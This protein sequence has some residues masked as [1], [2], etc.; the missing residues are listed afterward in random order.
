[1]SKGNL[2]NY[3]PVNLTEESFSQ[4]MLSP[5][6]RIERIVSKG[7]C[8]PE[9][10]WYDQDENEWVMVVEGAGTLLFS[11]GEEVTLVKG[12]YINIPANTKHK[13][14]WTDPYNET[15]WL[16]VFYP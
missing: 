3:M 2:F 4:L 13:V 10:G 14:T 12:D 16:A 9:V 15:I 7:H 5:S 11:D 8:S 1:M 6:V